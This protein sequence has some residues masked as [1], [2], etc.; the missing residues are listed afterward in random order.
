[1]ERSRN[2]PTALERGARSAGCTESQNQELEQSRDEWFSPGSN[3]V[4][5]M[6]QAYNISRHCDFQRPRSERGGCIFLYHPEALP[7]P[8]PGF[9]ILSTEASRAP[10]R[11]HGACKRQGSG[12]GARSALECGALA[13]LWTA[14]KPA[15]RCCA[16]TLPRR[17]ALFSE[18]NQSQRGKWKWRL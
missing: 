17:S 4:R 9:W 18:Q 2:R 14:A 5:S 6:R 11:T 3:L 13:P 12:S 7:D 1:M 16:A 10:G 8:G 15:K